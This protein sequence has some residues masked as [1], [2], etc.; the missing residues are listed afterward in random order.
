MVAAATISSCF[1]LRSHAQ[2]VTL[3]G[4]KLSA[5]EVDSF[6]QRSM[7]SLK[8][9]GLSMAIVQKGK[10]VYYKAAGIK[11][12]KREAVDSNTLFEAASMTK[13]VFAYT[14]QR[15]VQEGQ[16]HLD[17]PLY[18]YYSYDD[19]EYDDRYKRI[20]ARMVLSHTTG[21][22]NWRSGGGSEL[23]IQSEPGTKYAYSG[24]GFEYLSRV[25]RHLLNQDVSEMIDR[26]V[27]RPVSIRN[28]FMVKNR[29]VQDHLADGMKDNKEWGWN[30]VWQRPNVA[31]S[32]CTEAK[33]Y[34]R[35]IIRLM[36]ESRTHESV[37]Y[38]MSQ[39]QMQIDSCKWVCLGLFMEQTPYGTKYCHSGNTNNRFNSN[40]EFYADRDLGYV[41]FMN[42]HR[43]QAFTKCVNDF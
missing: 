37:F 33:E 8:I 17:T 22:P 40:F 24:E 9:P 11:N 26:E 27:F 25:V 14:V 32:L 13:P 34:A 36:S 18:R 38:Q 10:I 28:S 19:I 23:T 43:E 16:L 15:L 31:Y 7:D 41:F 4:K 12:D 21:F 35:F 1:F 2:V 5:A 6:I 29:Y 39:P 42:C 20:T 30:N 3:S